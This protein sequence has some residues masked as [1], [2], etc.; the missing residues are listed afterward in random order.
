MIIVKTMLDLFPWPAW[1]I[2][3]IR[4]L[5]PMQAIEQILVPTTVLSLISEDLSGSAKNLD[6]L[7]TMQASGEYGSFIFPYEDQEED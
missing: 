1:N 7:E 4:P 6:P 2:S 3:A 5:T